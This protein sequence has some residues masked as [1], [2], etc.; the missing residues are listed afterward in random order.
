MFL[1]G[2][3]TSFGCLLALWWPGFSCRGPLFPYRRGT[4]D[5]ARLDLKQH[6]TATC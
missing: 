4:T 2:G 1:A 3:L 5:A 6:P